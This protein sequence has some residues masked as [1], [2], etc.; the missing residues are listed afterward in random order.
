MVILVERICHIP[1]SS[2]SD[3]L[4]LELSIWGNPDPKIG[5]VESYS[6]RLD[7]QGNNEYKNIEEIIVLFSIKNN[8][9]TPGLVQITNFE[10]LSET[11]TGGTIQISTPIQQVA[12]YSQPIEKK[13]TITL[14]GE[15]NIKWTF[16]NI[17]LADDLLFKYAIPGKIEAIFTQG[18]YGKKFK[19]S[20][21][22]TPKFYKKT[23][24]YLKDNHPNPPKIE[25]TKVMENCQIIRS[26]ILGVKA[27]NSGAKSLDYH[28]DNETGILYKGGIRN[29]SL[30]AESFARLFL[31]IRNDTKNSKQIIKSAGKEVGVNFISKFSSEILMENLSAEEKIKKWIEYDSSAGMGKFELEGKTRIRV[32]NSFNAC[33]CYQ[34][35]K[36]ICYFLEGYLEGVL[37][38]LFGVNISVKEVSCAAMN[39]NSGNYCVF[40][41]AEKKKK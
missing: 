20:M 3:G 13:K 21:D 39:G 17:D 11:I 8:D 31:R 30:R 7:I 26:N 16:N 36:P 18:S 22:V 37:S 19:I 32:Y 15:N 28:F 1:D 33:N 34:E 40:A 10:P 35:K 25:Y 27:Q 23:Y 41:V 5:Q 29:V 2:E 38:Q 24:R 12:S 6:W 4:S 9:T 14:A